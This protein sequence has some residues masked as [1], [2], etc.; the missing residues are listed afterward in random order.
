MLTM[1]KI[2]EILKG[3]LS[4]DNE[5]VQERKFLQVEE[6]EDWVFNRTCV[7]GH[8]DDWKVIVNFPKHKNEFFVDGLICDME[9][10]K[11][12]DYIMLDDLNNTMFKKSRLTSAFLAESVASIFEDSLITGETALNILFSDGVITLM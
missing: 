11:Y 12:G 7:V 5:E 8:N 10:D 9:S 1:K 3:K 2:D 4:Y 6:L